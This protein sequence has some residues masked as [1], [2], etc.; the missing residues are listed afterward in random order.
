MGGGIT[1]GVC[2]GCVRGVSGVCQGCV[3]GVSAHKTMLLWQGL[4]VVNGRHYCT[5]SKAPVVSPW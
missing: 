4:A 2:Q 3:R 5:Q 1:G